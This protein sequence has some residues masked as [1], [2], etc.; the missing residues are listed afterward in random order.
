M[1]YNLVKEQGESE[2]QKG[3]LLKIIKHYES[4]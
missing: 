1:S 3:I 4:I 2:I